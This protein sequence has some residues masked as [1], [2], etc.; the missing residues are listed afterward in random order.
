MSE[1]ADPPP[2]R[3]A[4]LGAGASAWLVLAFGLPGAADAA[5]APVARGTFAPNAF[6]RMDG[7]GRVTLVLPQ[8]EMGQGVYTSLCQLLADE[9]DVSLAQVTFEASPPDDQLYGGPK[10]HR[11]STGGSTSIRNFYTPMRQAGANARAMLVTAGARG[12]KVDPA[13]C[14]TADGILFHDASG[15]RIAYGALAARAGAVKLAAD[16]PLKRPEQLKLIG[17]AVRRVDT[18]DK[19]N[20]RAQFGLGRAA[21][22]DED[23][24]AGAGAGGGRPGRPCRRY[25]GQSGVGR[26]AGGG[27]ARCRRGGGRS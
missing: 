23:R 15:R 27:A 4:V 9:L 1:A 7:A 18:P 12:W 22:G 6:I 2:S 3:R 19:T 25:A 24:H 20:G 5:A 17:K 26:A 11:Q 14:R 16:A 10:S 8:A 13:S 21:A